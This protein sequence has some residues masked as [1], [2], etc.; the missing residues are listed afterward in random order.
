MVF[1]GGTSLSKVF[2]LIGRFSEDIGLILD[3]R[4]LGYGHAEGNDPYLAITSKTKQSRY[5]QE[6]N[7]KAAN[8]I[9]G[10]LLGQLSQLFAAVSGVVA[11]IDGD[12]PH[13][14]N[15]F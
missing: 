14:V 13:T 11:S 9:R 7:A 2:G 6:M 1:K 4:L 12:D 3:W 15:V 5:N 10:T 8:Y